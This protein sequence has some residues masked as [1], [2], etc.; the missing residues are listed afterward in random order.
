ME[1][2]FFVVGFVGCANCAHCAY[3][4]RKQRAGKYAALATEDSIGDDSV[5][6]F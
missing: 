6:M 4:R 2:I 1:D 5:E 3:G